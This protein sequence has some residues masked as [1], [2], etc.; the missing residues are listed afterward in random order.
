MVSSIPPSV[1]PYP[2]LEQHHVDSKV[3][4]SPSLPIS[5]FSSSTFPSESMDSNNQVAKKKKKSDKGEASSAAIAPKKPS[6]DKPS[7]VPRKV[8]FPCMLCKGD[9]LLRDCP[10]IPKV[11]EAW[12][13]DLPLLPLASGSHIDGTS[14][15]S[16]DKTHKKQGKITN[17]CKLCEGYHP[18]HL[19]PYMDEATRVLD[20]P[21]FSAPCLL[22]GYQKLSS[23][24]PL[25]DS[26]ID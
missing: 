21:T 4:L 23:S 16:H 9:H 3:D 17:P 5:S 10:G 26:T 7:N 6:I 14:S 2:P 25:V 24:P 12:S 11:L 18:I 19:F 20:N 13:N 1:Q 15:T 8:K 22:A